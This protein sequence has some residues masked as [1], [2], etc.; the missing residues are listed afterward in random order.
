[1]TRERII[2]AIQNICDDVGTLR[3]GL[4]ADA[5][6][7]LVATDIAQ[8][9]TQCEG[10][11]QSA[12]NNGADVL[13]LEGERDRALDAGIESAIEISRL[14]EEARAKGKALA[15]MEDRIAAMLREVE[16]AKLSHEGQRRNTKRFMAERDELQRKLDDLLAVIH[17]DGGQYQAAHGLE[18]A[19]SDARVIIAAALQKD[20]GQ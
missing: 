11:A 15:V 5:I 6:L 2:D 3:A 14:R 20:G 16:S 12:L 1:M 13:R 17:R 8:L 4:A 10:L 19:Y 9:R 18:K 7:G